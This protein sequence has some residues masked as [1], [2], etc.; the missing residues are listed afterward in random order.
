MRDVGV[1]RTA[2]RSFCLLAFVAAICL[3]ASASLPAAE[4]CLL[5]QPSSLEITTGS[6][7]LPQGS[8]I[9]AERSLSREAESLCK[10]MGLTEGVLGGGEDL[11]AGAIRLLQD[12][13]TNANPEGY[14]LDV[15]PL[16]ITIRAAA[17]AGAF[18]GCQTLLQLFAPEPTA[19]SPFAG[20]GRT[21]MVS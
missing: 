20:L 4:V 12:T 8:R 3:V 7:R 10:E 9:A 19:I 14:S 11:T 2:A 16:Q 21:R 5:P 6:F 15:T 1:E 18:Y 17:P 13:A